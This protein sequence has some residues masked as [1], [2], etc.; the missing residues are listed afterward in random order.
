[1]ASAYFILIHSCL[2][3][4]RF[5]FIAQSSSSSLTRQ[6]PELKVVLTP[7]TVKLWLPH[8]TRVKC[9]LLFLRLAAP[10]SLS[11]FGNAVIYEFE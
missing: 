6:A 11:A 1:M 7:A 2:C 3:F 5:I 8:Q 10:A 4:C 9:T